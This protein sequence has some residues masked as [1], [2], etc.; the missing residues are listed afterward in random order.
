MEARANQTTRGALHKATNAYRERMA[1]RYA[2]SDGKVVL[3]LEEAPE[4]G[5]I[6]TAPFDP[7]LITEAETLSEA[8]QNARDATKAIRQSRAKLQRGRPSTNAPG[9]YK[10]TI[11]Q[12][13]AA[14]P[15]T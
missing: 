2:V 3:T 9:A 5:F 12:K 10:P 14:N 7:E 6:V 1:K 11:P 13:A 4:G 15:R 8:F